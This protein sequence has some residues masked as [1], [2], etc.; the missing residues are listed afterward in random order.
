MASTRAA[1]KASGGFF[2]S[3]AGTNVRVSRKRVKNMNLR[4]THDGRVELSIPWHCSRQ[5]AQEFVRQKEGWIAKSLARV[6]SQEAPASQCSYLSGDVTY[7]W[8]QPLTILLQEASRPSYELD[9]LAGTVTLCVPPKFQGADDQGVAYRRQLVAHMRKEELLRALPEVS[10]RAQSLVGVSCDDWHVRDMRTRW[11]SCS[12]KRRRIWL[13][14]ELAAR[15]KECLLGVCCHELCHLL[16]PNH[17]DAFYA[18]LER[19]FPDWRRV[20]AELRQT[21][22][23]P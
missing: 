21:P 14:T 1:G 6:Q 10:A 7:L 17:S 16:V 5:S 12:V 4:V 2:I 20:R 8:G 13:A 9:L 3:A 23:L 15:P 19:S 22:R 18:Q 11:G